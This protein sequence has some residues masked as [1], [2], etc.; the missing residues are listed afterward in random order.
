MV[1]LTVAII[2]SRPEPIGWWR[3]PRPTAARSR[4]WCF[5]AGASARFPHRG[6]RQAW[7]DRR[8]AYGAGS[9]V[10]LRC[11]QLRAGARPRHRAR[12]AQ[13]PT[14]SPHH[15]SHIRPESPSS[16]PNNL[17]GGKDLGEELYVL[18]DPAVNARRAVY[19][20]VFEACAWRAASLAVTLTQRPHM[21]STHA[22]RSFP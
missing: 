13:T 16:A 1:A 6:P 8:L 4:G 14:A 2:L 5:P 21:L 17:S 12:R 18:R 7:Y 20:D 11:G 22:N 9:P 3:W 10:P 19:P 15:R